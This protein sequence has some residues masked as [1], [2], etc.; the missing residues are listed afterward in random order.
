[1]TVDEI[2]RDLSA[3]MIQ[4]MMFHEQLANYYDFLGLE[5]YK[6]CHEYHFFEETCGY[7]KLCRYFINHHSKLVPYKE[8]DDPGVIPDS[9]YKYE[10]QDVDA[11]TK[12]NAVKSGLERWVNWERETKKF[13]ES[14]YRELINIG[15]VASAKFLCDYIEDVDVEL[16]YAE[17]YHISK[18]S[19]GYDMVYIIEEQ[20]KKHELYK[21]KLKGALDCLC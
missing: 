6:R 17:R 18:A 7:R 9:W 15:E 19:T 2:Y 1:M 5:G 10:R 20:P 11:G 3:H 13:Y 21:D 8:V 14:M 16:K 12:K 4:G